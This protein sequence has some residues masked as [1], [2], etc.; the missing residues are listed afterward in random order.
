MPVTSGPTAI[1]PVIVDAV[2]VDPATVDPGLAVLQPLER[3]VDG[4]F[5]EIVDIT[6]QDA[7][8]VFRS[9]IPLACSVAYGATPSLGMIATSQDMAGGA[10]IDHDPVLTGLQPDT[11][12]FYRVQ[13]TAAD[14]TIYVGEMARFTTARTPEQVTETDEVRPIGLDTVAQAVSIATVSSNFGGAAND[15]NWGAG[16]AVDGNGRTAWSSDGD[17]DDAFLE[18]EFDGPVKIAAVEVQTRTM[19]DGSAQIFSF[20]LTGDDG[21]S[22][23]PFDLP[24]AAK[25][26]HFDVELETTH[27]RFDAA[28]SS[29][30]NTGLVEFVVL[31][32][33]E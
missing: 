16:Q 28:T 6:H 9:T 29:G 8:L 19:S 30:G 31:A 14:G 26:Y 13:G 3:V 25:I 21:V 27:L 12:Y 10:I 7:M 4:A 5:P 32:T 15:Q 23:G 11:E 24:D 33:P 18:V 20:T 17:G 1:D 2:T 22:H